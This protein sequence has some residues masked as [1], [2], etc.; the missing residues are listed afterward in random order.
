VIQKTLG[1][2]MNS[3]RSAGV[4]LRNALAF[5]PSIDNALEARSQDAHFVLC[6]KL[7]IVE[8]ILAA[9]RAC[10]LR[11]KSDQRLIDRAHMFHNTWYLVFSRFLSTGVT[12]ASVGKIFEGITF[13]VFNYDRCVEQ[14]LA[15]AL[16]AYF[17][18]PRQEVRDIVATANIVH[19]YGS[20]G[21]LDWQAG[22]SDPCEFGDSL[23]GA[24]LAKAAQSIRTFSERIEEPAALA[25]IRQPIADADQIAF[26]GFSYGSQN[27]ELLFGDEVLNRKRKF[28]GSTY[29]VSNQNA[30]SIKQYLE[31]VGCTRPMNSVFLESEKCGK[32]L[33]NHEWPLLR[34]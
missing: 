4:A 30:E 27:M 13:V 8:R 20:V 25:R 15:M 31:G 14:Y 18:I 33:S 16:E 32:F 1:H 21:R 26:L 29:Q 9:E 12:R 22:T 17:G 2:D 28:F 19:P 7:A 24:E 10:P 3:L 5:A 34:D 6:G 11:V 23:S